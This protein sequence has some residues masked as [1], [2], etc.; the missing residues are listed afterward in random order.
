MKKIIKKLFLILIV[1]SMIGSYLPIVSDVYAA[2]DVA[3]I[4][5]YNSSNTLTY[6]Q[7]FTSPTDS[8][9]KLN[10]K[11]T[12]GN[13]VV[14]EIFSDIA[15]DARIT[16]DDNTKLEIN[17]NGHMLRRA[18]AEHSDGEVILVDE[19]SELTIN[20][21]SD[22]D[23]KN[24]EHTI[25]YT[26]TKGD[27]VRNKSV[28]IKGGLIT[29]GYSNSGAGGILAKEDSKVTLNDV[30]L[31]GNIARGENGGGITLDGPNIKLTMNNSTISYNYAGGN[32]GFTEG[33]GGGIYVY[34]GIATDAE[35]CTVEMNNSHI[36]NN[37][38]TWGGGIYVDA[39]HFTLTGDAE[40][41]YSLKNQ[42]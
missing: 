36:D 26:D 10:E 39:E 3:E 13:R 30:S 24:I 22:E 6:S 9:Y 4:R 31:S 2:T 35:Y 23:A 27:Y 7:R 37:F 40:A 25:Y 29:G 8:I 12:S 17:L 38:A 11:L 42:E 20:G 15:V 34:G 41:N 1:I 14:Y 16:M 19:D 5:V 21:G 18:W 28:T 32:D 33:F